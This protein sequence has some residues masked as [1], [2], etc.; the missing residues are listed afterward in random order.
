ML[1]YW[2][3]IPRPLPLPGGMPL[4][5]CPL[6]SPR[7]PLPLGGGGCG[8]YPQL[9]CCCCWGPWWAGVVVDSPYACVPARGAFHDGRSSKGQRCVV[10]SA[11]WHPSHVDSCDAGG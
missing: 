3:W 11:P 10:W 5:G 8:W 9:S 7:E 2:Y 4:G 1:P 6:P